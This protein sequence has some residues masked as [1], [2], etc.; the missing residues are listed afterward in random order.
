M[1][2]PTDD[3]V[4]DAILADTQSLA[5]A[6]AGRDGEAAEMIGLKLPPSIVSTQVNEQGLFALFEDPADAEAVMQTLEG[7]AAS[8]DPSA[9]VIKRML[10]WL[11]PPAPGLN[12][13]SGVVREIIDRFHADGL[14]TAHQRDVLKGAAERPATVDPG[15]VSRIWNERYR[16]DGLVV[17]INRGGV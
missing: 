1:S 8:Q 7:V 12:L 16:P 14:F 3:E 11:R 13:G 6:D 9:P 10:G 4:H 17:P 15:R 5:L 2:E